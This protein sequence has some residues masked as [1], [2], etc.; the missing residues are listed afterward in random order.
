MPQFF[1]VRRGRFR[2]AWAFH[3]WL[4]VNVNVSINN[5]LAISCAG[6]WGYIPMQ[7]CNCPIFSVMPREDILP[8]RNLIRDPRRGMPL[9][10]VNTDVFVSTLRVVRA[11]WRE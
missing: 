5:L 2:I 7:A 11:L 3:P 4:P 9:R 1:L 6:S 10:H 8:V